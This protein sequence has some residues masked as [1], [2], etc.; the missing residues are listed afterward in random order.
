MT[1]LTPEVV[2]P[3][4]EGWPSTYFGGPYPLSENHYLVSW[5]AAPLPP[6]TPRPQW[7]MP[8]PPN[9]LGIYLFD[10]FGNL[11]LVY[12]DPT[13]GS[14]TPLPIR[15]RH[16]EP[17]VRA[18]AGEPEG[19][20]GRM[21]IQ[22]VYQGLPEQWQGAIRELRVVGIPV[23]THPTM[24]YPSMGITRDDPGKFVLGT[25]PVE[26]DG[27]AYFR[28]P[29]GVPFF[30]QVLDDEGRAVQTM[31]SATYL[32]AGQT[33]TCIGCHEPRNTAPPARM[34]AALSRAPSSLM[35]G[36]SGS[37]PLDFQTL[38]GPVLS[39]HCVE[40]HRPE[41]EAPEFDLRPDKA[42]DALV[43]YGKPSLR[44]HVM[45]RYSQGRSTAG[46]GASQ[47]SPLADLLRRGHYDVQLQ[48]DEWIR[49]YT[50]M[51][52]YGQRLGS[53]GPEQEEQLRRLRQR[54][55]NMLAD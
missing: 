11:N 54:L 48:R 13:I 37:W 17:Q 34:A 25:V 46:A 31:R 41:G 12:R 14:E 21:L 38:V 20:E 4:T 50:W 22:D 29:A 44:Q 9:D 1:R 3:E 18:L 39:Q 10:A 52:T 27:S 5:S 24:N 35:P 47:E 7:G 16:R 23:K 8:G 36:P 2:F 43:D 6:G 53:F 55:A 15:P 32:Q 40:C 26:R 28:V 45:T 30:L 51:D 42:Y 19:A 49:L 33:F